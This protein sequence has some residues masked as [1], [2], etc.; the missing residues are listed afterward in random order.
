LGVY[1]VKYFSV[2]NGVFIVF[3]VNKCGKPA[4]FALFS[5]IPGGIEVL[6]YFFDSLQHHPW[7]GHPPPLPMVGTPSNI[8]TY[9][10]DNISRECT[11]GFL[12][13]QMLRRSNKETV[14]AIMHEWLE[15]PKED[16]DFPFK[17]LNLN[18]VSEVIYAPSCPD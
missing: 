8:F 5:Y 1:F 18:Q 9:I 13:T 11:T 2:K 14:P 4:V 7:A 6:F 3:K 12:E 10:T 15:N 16:W 17:L